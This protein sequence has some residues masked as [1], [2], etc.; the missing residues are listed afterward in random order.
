MT[1][2]DELEQKTRQLALLMALDKVR[3]SL[4]VENNPHGMFRQIAQILTEHFLAD[5]AGVMLL[6]DDGREI[7]SIASEGAPLDMT[8]AVCRAVMA[9]SV[10]A[11][12]ETPHWPHVL[13][14]RIVQD[15]TDTVL[16]GVFVARGGTAFTDAEIDL[17][18]VAECQIDSAVMQ[19][20]RIWALASRNV[21]L[22]A[23]YQID[24]ARDDNPQE[25]EL[26]GRFT[27]LLVEY[28][29]AD[30]CL[31]FLSH[32]DSGEMLLRGM[33]DRENV[34]GET[35][36]ALR[37][38]TGRITIPQIIETP[39]TLNQTNLLAAPFVVSG[40]RLGSVVVGRRR[41]FTLA[42]HNLLFA[43]MSQMDSALVYS[44]VVQQLHQRNKELETI[45]RIDHIRDQE[46]DLDAMLQK[47]LNELCM[48]VESEVGYL[49]L[50][51]ETE[52]RSLELKATTIDAVLTSPAYYQAIQQFSRQALKQGEPVYSNKPVGPVRSI[53]AIPLILNEQVI[54]VF[55]VIN[56]RSP[57][58]FSAEDRRV[59]QAVTSQV[60]TAVFE[61]L[62]HRRMRRALSRSVDPKVID[63]L[64]NRADGDILS[65]D[66]AVISM[67]F[68]DLRGS[69]AWTERTD[70]EELVRTLNRF[71]GAMTDVIFKH[72]G[73][74][75]KF[76]GD[77]VIA[78][79]GVPVAMENH[80][81]KAV[82]CACEMRDVQQALREELASKG[83][84]LPP[85]GVGIS[86]GEV[87]AGEIGSPV[88]TDFTAL[89]RAMNLGARLCSAASPD[90]I[91]ISDTV[92]QAV[93]GR[94]EAIALSTLD[95]KGLGGVSAYELIGLKW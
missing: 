74:L 29:E 94:V 77:E 22:E 71:L 91:L 89:G 26:I 25:S 58:G 1:S 61:R 83:I 93:T 40:V 92:Y 34:P 51:S 38:L 95:L 17:L 24:R 9:L 48:A 6:A 50:F 87:I 27:T 43:M 85:M 16:G 55:G 31:V 45:Y 53:V 59:L 49:M 90:Q 5:A 14:V 36:E 7:E 28:F 88:R 80:T 62:E 41:P 82:Q 84:E 12:I 86:T 37:D 81:L 64:L 2:V 63:H 13:G 20:R 56:S 35:L 69:T 42:D 54:G 8:E 65:G 70:P 18:R 46:T 23:I 15:E 44:R 75:D 4:D 39:H 67:I 78:L 21:E 60:D 32:I 72:G 3:D 76:V 19:A 57:Y 68:C 79:F 30:I 66:R 52:E 11:L 10:P 73:L 33:V 47:V